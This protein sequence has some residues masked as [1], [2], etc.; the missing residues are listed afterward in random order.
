MDRGRRAAFS[1]APSGALKA[2]RGSRAGRTETMLMRRPQGVKRMVSSRA[3]QTRRDAPC[4]TR[5]R[6]GVHNRHC[7]QTRHPDA[8]YGGSAGASRAENR[9]RGGRRRSRPTSH[10]LRCGAARLRGSSA[11][12]DL[13]LTKRFCL[14]FPAETTAPRLAR[15]PDGSTSHFAVAKLFSIAIGASKGPSEQARPAYRALR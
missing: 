14:A 6:R 7:R 10:P 11:G 9:L 13:R 12:R 8:P 1:R 4:S 3:M 5:T 15:A 2:G